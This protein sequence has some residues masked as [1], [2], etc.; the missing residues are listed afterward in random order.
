MH[1]ILV[2]HSFVRRMR[3]QSGHLQDINFAMERNSV[4]AR[5]LS[6]S[7]G[8]FNCVNFAYTISDG[9]NVYE[10]LPIIF[11]A[12]CDILVM[13]MGS[14][15]LACLSKVDLR[16]VQRLACRYYE[17]AINTGA[18]AVLFVGVLKRTGRL[19]CSPSVFN[20]NRQIFNRKLKSLC[21]RNRRVHFQ[22]LRGFESTSSQHSLNVSS[23]SQDGIHPNNMMHYTRRLAFAVMDYFMKL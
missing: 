5:D 10:D 15:D 13:N 14:N 19:N 12:Q 22:K 2:G 7:L 8:W 17:W 9:C 11:D 3:R 4:E 6:R 20:V 21:V 16:S 23:W 18:R 1:G